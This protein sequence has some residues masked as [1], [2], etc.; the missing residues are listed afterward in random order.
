MWSLTLNGECPKGAEPRNVQ[1]TRSLLTADVTFQL[2][3]EGGMS[4]QLAGTHW[5]SLGKKRSLENF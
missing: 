2:Q 4:G 1:E 5:L 3:G